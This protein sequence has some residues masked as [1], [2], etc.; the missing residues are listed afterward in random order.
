[1]ESWQ[2][3]TSRFSIGDN[4]VKEYGPKNTYLLSSLLSGLSLKHG[5]TATSD[6]FLPCLLNCSVSDKKGFC[7]PFIYIR[8]TI[9]YSKHLH[10][11]L[12]TSYLSGSFRV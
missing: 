12:P 3:N 6:Q 9:I 8:R 5:L 7:G 1:M 2:I 11:Q 10:I 4:E